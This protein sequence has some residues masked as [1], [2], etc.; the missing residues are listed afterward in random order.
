[1]AAVIVVAD[2]RN[3]ACCGHVPYFEA[4]LLLAL[5]SKG[6]STSVARLHDDSP[7]LYSVRVLWV[8]GL[9]SMKNENSPESIF[10]GISLKFRFSLDSWIFVSRMKPRRQHGTLDSPVFRS[11]QTHRLFAKS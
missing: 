7:Q 5:F 2:P 3:D 1:M 4:H 6:L 10:S 9:L 11:I 8:S